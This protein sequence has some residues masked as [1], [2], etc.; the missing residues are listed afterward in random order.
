MKTIKVKAVIFDMDG[1]ITDTMSYHFRAWRRIYATEGF[2]VTR[3]EIYRKEGQSGC[4]T[5]REIFAERGIPL[6]EARARRILAEKE[7]I[8]KKIVRKR[9]IRGARGFLRY[10][11]HRGIAAAL[12]TGTARHEVEEILSKCF[13]KRFAVSVMGDEVKHGKPHP[14]PYLRALKKMHIRPEDAVV[15]ENAPFG[16]RSAKKAGLAC[17]ALE[18]SLGQVFLKEADFV[19]SSYRD[20]RRHLDFQADRED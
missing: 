7:K 14:E 3:E 16:I 8:F 18:T 2:R 1:V 9:F 10:L 17:V 15:I 5:I 11:H 6:D 19:F 4:R 20:L 12:V 13:L